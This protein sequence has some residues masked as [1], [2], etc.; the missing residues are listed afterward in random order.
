MKTRR[1]YTEKSQVKET[2]TGCCGSTP[3]QVQPVQSSCCGYPQQL[4]KQP[5]TGSKCC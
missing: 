2:G 1:I 5:Q 3:E 4:D